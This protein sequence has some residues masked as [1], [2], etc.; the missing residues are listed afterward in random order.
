MSYREIAASL[1]LSMSAVETRIHRAKK[2]LI[3]KLEPIL[4]RI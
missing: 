1:E 2:Q 4:D 3:K